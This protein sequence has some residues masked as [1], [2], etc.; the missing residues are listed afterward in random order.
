MI[1]TIAI[2]SFT[3]HGFQ[4]GKAFTQHDNLHQKKGNL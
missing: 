4:T 3:L 1:V 2:S